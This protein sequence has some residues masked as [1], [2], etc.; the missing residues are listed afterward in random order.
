MQPS[1]RYSACSGNNHEPIRYRENKK[2]LGEFY[3]FQLTCHYHNYKLI[4]YIKITFT[5]LLNRC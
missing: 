3:N 5:L 4:K 1:Q 2:S